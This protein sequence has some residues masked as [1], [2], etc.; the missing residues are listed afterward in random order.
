MTILAVKIT[1]VDE[2]NNNGGLADGSNAVD[3]AG[4][5]H[6]YIKYMCN[7]LTHNY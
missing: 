7:K 5:D 1:L 3:I 4:T 2:P 6:I